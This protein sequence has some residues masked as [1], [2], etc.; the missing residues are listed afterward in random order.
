VIPE[1]EARAALW[2]Q[3]QATRAAAV[4]ARYAA[5]AGDPAR[6]QQTRD[7]WEPRRPTG[8]G[9]QRVHRRTRRIRPA[10][11]PWVDPSQLP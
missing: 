9:R 6:A 8:T 11:P 7:A 3:Q 10:R 2:R 5:L 1:E 4:T